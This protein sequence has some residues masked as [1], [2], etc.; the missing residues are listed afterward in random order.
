MWENF[1]RARVKTMRH[2]H[3][4]AGNFAHQFR[5]KNIENRT[6][7]KNIWKLSNLIEYVQKRAKIH[8]TQNY[9]PILIQTMI[10]DARYR[11]IESVATGCIEKSWKLLELF[12]KN[13]WKYSNTME[14]D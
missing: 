3:S 14:W 7:S 10:G 11:K 9:S 13:L 1:V 5:R 2:A 8:M 12:L 6:N 4:S